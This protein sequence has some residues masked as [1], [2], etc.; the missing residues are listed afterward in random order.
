MTELTT[1]VQNRMH[2]RPSAMHAVLNE[3][4]RTQLLEEF[5][6]MNATGANK[7]Y[8]NQR[9]AAIDVVQ[10]FVGPSD[11][12]GR[13]LL[14]LL[15]IARTQSGKTG[16]ASAIIQEFSKSRE[17]YV[18]IENIYLITGVSSKE[19]VDQT[20][21]RMPPMLRS[22]V[23]HRPHL[24]QKFLTDL[25]NKQ[26]VLIITD[27]IQVAAT[28]TQTLDRV[29]I[30]AGLTN[31]DHMLR[32]DIKLVE[33]TA[34]PDGTAYDMA[35]WKQHGAKMVVDPG[36]GYTS[37]YDLLLQNRIRSAERLEHEPT[38]DYNPFESIREDMATFKT[39]KYHIVRASTY[40]NNFTQTVKNLMKAFGNTEYK[41]LLFDQTSKQKDINVILC[42]KPAKHTFIL[43]KETL[44]C[45]KSLVK[46]HLGILYDRVV[47]SGLMSNSTIVQSLLGR[48]TGY[49][50]NG[51]SIVYTDIESI[52]RYE[53]LW[54]SEFD[55]TVSWRSKTTRIGKKIADPNN[56]TGDEKITTSKKT[57][58][59]LVVADNNMIE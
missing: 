20:K 56:E 52:E 47:E 30:D 38:K 14:N 22:R 31:I 51:E 58:L 53:A 55:E 13:A 50:D 10:E 24:T 41:Y 21:A 9:Q 5:K 44:R 39:P 8:D 4:K 46:T 45:A 17:T 7:I 54:D 57:F 40:L 12:K 43:I 35:A 42:T 29:F 19:W 37:S 18:P 26:N 3:E 23:F 11:D 32:N 25:K 1:L 36:E 49:D 2:F 15:L 27:E 33:I 59:T 28:K 16:I 48:C 34:T 6:S